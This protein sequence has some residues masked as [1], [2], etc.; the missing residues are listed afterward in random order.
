MRRQGAA[1]RAGRLAASTQEFVENASH[2]LRTPI[3]I[4][5]GHAQLLRT[6]AVGRQAAADV[7]VV[8]EELE[9]LSRISD[10]LLILAA[11]EQPSFLALAPVD[12]HTLVARS[13]D[14]WRVPATSRRWLVDLAVDGTLPA[15]EERLGSAIDALL[16]NAVKYTEED[17]VICVSARAAGETAAIDVWDNGVGIS[18]EELPRIFDRFYR[19]NGNGN[20]HGN[21]HG[22]NGNGAGTNGGTGLGLAIVKAIVEAHGGTVAVKSDV[23]RGTR[24]SVRLGGFRSRTT[25]TSAIGAPEPAL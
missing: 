14:R 15:D 2:E 20:G 17:A 21:G 1:E 10:R 22:G 25:A 19:G 6:T 4:A 18:P 24:F 8:L 23:G 16:E 12:L 9:R 3:T 11:A 13:V 5:R 7:E